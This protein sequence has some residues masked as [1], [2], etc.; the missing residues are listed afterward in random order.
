[1]GRFKT[2]L[3][4]AFF[5]YFGTSLMAA[6]TYDYGPQYDMSRPIREGIV[7][8]SLTLIA[9]GAGGI[10]ANVSPLGA[11]Q[12]EH[13]G[14]ETVS[15]FFSWFYCLLQAS[16]LFAYT[17]VTYIQQ[18]ISFF[19]AY[20]VGPICSFVAILL[21]LSGRKH[22]V[23]H[24][25]RGSAL[26]DA[27]R[28]T[29]S[30][31]KKTMRNRGATPKTEHCLDRAKV[32]AG[33]EYPDAQVDGVK[34]L[35][36]LIPIFLTFIMF[37]TT[38]GQVRKGSLWDWAGDSPEEYFVKGVPL[39]PALYHSLSA[40]HIYYLFHTQIILHYILTLS[41]PNCVHHIISYHIMVLLPYSRLINQKFDLFPGF[42]CFLCLSLLLTVSLSYSCLLCLRLVCSLTC[43]HI[44]ESIQ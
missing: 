1:M 12:I 10:K 44:L 30:G 20:L 3:A 17:I 38:F 32:S 22:Y 5:F 37:S 29:W 27:A 11:D 7:G 13:E 18:E 4:S 19:Y 24:P 16:T 31:F 21:F 6:V 2:V 9:I 43:H 42:R 26:T 28:I 23:T 8:V 36:R 41:R 33:G 25:P 39:R 34:S 40:L 15:R 35:L 14:P